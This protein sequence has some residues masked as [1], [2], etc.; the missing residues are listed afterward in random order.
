MF[1]DLKI[2]RMTEIKPRKMRM[3]MTFMQHYVFVL[4]FCRI[5]FISPFFYLSYNKFQSIPFWA[6]MIWAYCSSIAS[7]IFPA[8]TF[9]LLSPP[10]ILSRRS[11]ISSSFFL[12]FSRICFSSSFSSQSWYFSANSISFK[13]TESPLF[14]YSPKSFFL[15][16][17]RLGASIESSMFSW[18]F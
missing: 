1:L 16:F 8:L 6:L 5:Y 9:K 18:F 13:S 3:I 2:A 15:L 10:M 7:P 14:L 11:S 12:N 17:S 4:N